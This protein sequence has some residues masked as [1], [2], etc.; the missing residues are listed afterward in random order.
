MPARVREA[1]SFA[2]QPRC[3]C[4]CGTSDEMYQGPNVSM[5]SP[6]RVVMF[7]NLGNVLWQ[8]QQMPEAHIRGVDA[9]CRQCAV[10]TSPPWLWWRR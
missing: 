5:A 9:F 1:L 2:F 3:L 10:G 4:G 7:W 6:T 8:A